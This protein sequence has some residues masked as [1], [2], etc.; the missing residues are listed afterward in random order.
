MRYTVEVWAPPGVLCDVAEAP[1]LAEC[2]E[3][4]HGHWDRWPGSVAAYG[5]ADRADIDA[6]GLTDA[7]RDWLQGLEP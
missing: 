5:N 1:T 2:V 4:V 3:A 7:E 6:D